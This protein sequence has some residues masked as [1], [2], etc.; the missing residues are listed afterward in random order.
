MGTFPALMEFTSQ[1]RETDINQKMILMNESHAW[2]SAM[3]KKRHWREYQGFKEGF[4]QETIARQ[5]AEGQER[6][7]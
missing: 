7:R 1:I 6:I 3:K 5:S 4:L 2:E